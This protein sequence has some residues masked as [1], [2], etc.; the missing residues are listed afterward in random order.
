[1]APNQTECPRLEQRSVIKFLVTEKCKLYEIY[2]RICNM[3][4]EAC[5]NKKKF[6]NGR[7]M[8]LQLQAWAVHGV[9]THRFSG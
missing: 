3:Y 6:T 5:F 4:N 7:N 2:R 9:E 1:M 8:D